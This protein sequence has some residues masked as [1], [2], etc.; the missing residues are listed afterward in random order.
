[1]LVA[2]VL[3]LGE[4][5]LCD[6][7]RSIRYAKMKAA[8]LSGEMASLCEEIDSIIDP[9]VRAHARKGMIYGE[10]SGLLYLVFEELYRRYGDRARFVLLTRKPDAFA[11]SALA[12]GFFDPAHPY[13]LEHLRARPATEI[14]GRWDAAT[15]FEKCLWYWDLVNGM[16]TDFF[17][18]LPDGL[19]RIQPIET[20]N[21][22]SCGQLY[23][24][25]GIEGFDKKK[26]EI[27]DL[28]SVRINATPG[29]GNGDQVNPWS[30]EVT[31]GGISEWNCQQREIY[32][33][34]TRRLLGKLYPVA[35]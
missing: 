27:R 6:H 22:S 29:Q 13:P 17:Q 24:F 35:Q 7:E 5:S 1:M 21:L 10:S 26:R 4:N 33:R 25:L 2:K 20:F 3:S 14:G 15:P 34:W 30:Q 9:M 11:R 31:L 18:R 32:E 8:Y 28:L 16:V 19:W 23:E 12:R